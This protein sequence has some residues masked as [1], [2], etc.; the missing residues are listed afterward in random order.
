MNETGTL[1]NPFPGLRPFEEEEEPLFFGRDQA[2]IELLSRLRTSRFLAVIGT[3]G[4]GKSSLVKAGLLPSLH[5]GFM[6]GA[7]SG[8][9]VALFRPGCDPIGNLAESLTRARVFYTGDA[10]D[11]EPDPAPA[12]IQQRIIETTLRRSNRGMIEIAREA[13]LPAHEN[14]LVVVDQFEEL[15]RFEKLEKSRHEERQDSAAFVELLLEVSRQTGFPV[16]IILTMRSEF[17]GSC[18]EFRGLPEALNRGQYLIPRMTREEKREA[19]IGP[20]AIGGAAVTPMLVSRLLNDVGDNPDQLPILQHALR[21]TWDYWARIRREGDPLDLVH[22]E[23]VGTMARALSRHAEEA[24]AELKTRRSRTICEK[25]FK[26]LIEV[27]ERG[28]AIRRPARVRDICRMIDASE[29]EVIDVI[30]VFRRPGR[31]FLMPPGTVGLGSDSDIDISHESLMRIW[32]RLSEWVT[33]EGQS[34]ELY[35]RLAKA[36]ALY[37]EGKAGLWRDPELM[38]ALEWQGKNRPNALWAQRYDPSFRRGKSLKKKKS[39]E[40][41]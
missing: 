11:R 31:T 18:T 37:E 40:Q 3:S 22:Y 15:F 36:A 29:K 23:A 19:V 13:R 5:G 16:Y 17:L 38:L 39:K 4:S 24:Y 2:V 26:L 41:K 33:E 27:D 34:A 6:A 9:R 10:D 12:A 14:L 1:T 35:L 20:I 32:T 21:R 28:Y 25:L 30:H 7:G 8:W